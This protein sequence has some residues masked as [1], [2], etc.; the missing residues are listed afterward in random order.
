MVTENVK[1]RKDKKYKKM[2][3]MHLN[4]KAFKPQERK[5]E[6]IYNKAMERFESERNNEKH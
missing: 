4:I 2:E 1:Y 5:V 6:G 3:V